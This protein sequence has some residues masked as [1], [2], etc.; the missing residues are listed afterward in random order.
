MTNSFDSQG[1]NERTVPHENSAA[2]GEAKVDGEDEGDNKPPAKASRTSDGGL[3]R[4]ELIALTGSTDPKEQRRKLAAMRDNTNQSTDDKEFLKRM[5]AESVTREKNELI[6]LAKA[7]NRWTANWEKFFE[8]KPND[9]LREM[10]S[11]GAMQR[12][13][14]EELEPLMPSGVEGITLL[15][16]DAR[17]ITMCRVLGVSTDPKEYAKVKAD[18]LSLRT[19]R[20]DE[21][22]YPMSRGG[23]N[24]GPKMTKALMDS[25][26]GL[27]PGKANSGD[28]RFLSRIDLRRTARQEPAEV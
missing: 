22:G 4:D 10:L 20:F 26:M 19:N 5:R 9:L 25:W 28:K 7:E 3:T 8:N 23:A 15:R 18:I 16:S 24:L 13:G 6:A 17:Y 1:A 14:G 21:Q 2:G 12:V 11:S 27:K